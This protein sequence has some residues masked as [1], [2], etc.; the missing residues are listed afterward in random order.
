M[1]ATFDILRRWTYPLVPEI[2]ASMHQQSSST[3]T[4]PTS[5][6][7]RLN[8]PYLSLYNTFRPIIY[9]KHNIYKQ[10]DIQL[11]RLS[12]IQQDVFIGH[13]SQILSGVRLRS[14][15]IGQNFII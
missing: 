5:P 15:L 10:G 7:V 9:D 14:S 12:N 6:Q 2:I 3:V 13:K 11:D 4:T 1:K 8:D